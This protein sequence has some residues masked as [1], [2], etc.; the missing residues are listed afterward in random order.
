M[1]KLILPIAIMML[2]LSSCKKEGCI[3]SDATNYNVEAKKDNGT[4]T[5]E[6]TVVFW[7]NQSTQDWLYNDFLADNVYFYINDK[8]FATE[9]ALTYWTTTP[10]CGDNG[11]IEYTYDL[12]G[13]K[14]QAATYKVIDNYGD[15]VWSGIINFNA[16]TC[17]AIELTN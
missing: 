15:Q 8:Q 2:T 17:L 6:S 1:K 3:D 16:N 12:A 9:S 11:N 4:C 5:Y 13:N 7:W 14:T 10:N